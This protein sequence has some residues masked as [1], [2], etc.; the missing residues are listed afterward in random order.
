[1][2][3]KKFYAVKNGRQTGIFESWSECEK[4]VSGFKNAEFEGFSTK[5]EA[6]S[7]LGEKISEKEEIKNLP[8]S[9][10]LYA[11][12]DGSYNVK[13]GAFGYG[14]VLIMPTGE[15]KEIS[16]SDTNEN[17]GSM[18]NVAG[19]IKGAFLSMQYAVNNKYKKLVIYH[20][21]EGIS[22]WAEHKWKA[23]LPQTKAYSEFCDKIKKLIDLEFV[24]VVAHT[25]VEYNER[26]DKLAK[27]A[28]GIE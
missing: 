19:E 7:Y 10:T 24:K 5:N 6:L 21:Y 22:K 27:K 16:G 3:K 13:T 14:A 12:V 4:Q 15:I 26:A 1:M 8:S 11:Y 20:D 18:R 28:L 23:N 2:A 9:D 25:G 17:A